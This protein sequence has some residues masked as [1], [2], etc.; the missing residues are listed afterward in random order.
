MKPCPFCAELIQDQAAKCRYCGEWLDPSKRPAWSGEPIP[1]APGPTPGPTSGRS[2]GT[3]VFAPPAPPSSPSPGPVGAAAHGSGAS[4]I[5][6]TDGSTQQAL[7]SWSTPP[8]LAGQAEG[9]PEEGPAASGG[10]AGP[11][12]AEAADRASLEDVALRMEKIKASAA[13]VRGAVERQ[14]PGQPNQPNQP[15]RA[16]ARAE[17]PRAVPDPMPQPEPFP[18]GFAPEDEE[19]TGP[20]DRP[21]DDGILPADPPRRDPGPAP[22][23]EPMPEPSADPMGAEPPRASRGADAFSDDFL[24][25][26]DGEDENDADD[27]AGFGDDL[28]DFGDEDDYDDE[29]ADD[30]DE[31]GSMAAASRPLP[32]KPILIGAGLLVVVGAVVFADYIFPK[33]DDATAA[34]DTDGSAEQDKAEGG[35]DKA[36]PPPAEDKGKPVTP[37]DAAAPAQPAAAEGGTPEAAAGAEGGTPPAAAGAE[38]GE[39]P[40]DPAAVAGTPAPPAPLDAETLAKLTEARDL[41]MAA[42]GRKKGKLKKAKALLEGEVLTA[43]PEHPEALLVLAQVNLELGKTKDAIEIAT[44]CTERSADLADCWLVIGIV[45]QDGGDKETAK[46]AYKKYRDLAPDGKYAG[47]VAKQLARWGE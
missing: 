46:A 28:D 1:S 24:G 36:D 18:T 38:G 10:L 21:F 34:A 41:W 39:A 45:S 26:L 27:G 11:G 42:E 44:K 35:D 37:E 29:F 20:A 4:G 13:A 19:D 32:W 22:M 7:R 2:G 23:P 9:Q 5:T 16:P 3:Q 47:D 31:F 30:D 25:D 33:G 17:G 6:A 43:A 15:N 14:A 12:V 40:A 8:W